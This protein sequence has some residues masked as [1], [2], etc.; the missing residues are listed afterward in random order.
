MTE[1]ILTQV[2]AGDL[3]AVDAC[4]KRYSG[5]LW[6][7]ARRFLPTLHDAEDAVQEVFL[8]LWKSAHRFDANAGS[9]LTFVMTIARRRLIDRGRR[10]ARQ[11][12][13]ESLPDLDLQAEPQHDA[14]E[15]REEAERVRAAML[16]I[17][18]E[19]RE[20]LQL[21]LLHGQTHQ[22]VAERTGLP[23]GTVKSHA[24]RGLMRVREIL[25]AARAP[26]GGD[27]R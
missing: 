18:P 16:Q 6:S 25:G 3:G 2:A 7:L 9:E 10:R 27:G 22:Q 5:P 13:A 19:Q 8:E 1:S 21:S 12:V 15:V 24:R 23:L 4:I 17:R 26:Q 11:G 14:V 20:V